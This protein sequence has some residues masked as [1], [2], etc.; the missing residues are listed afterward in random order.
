MKSIS[1]SDGQL[2]SIL[3]RRDLQSAAQLTAGS[4]LG[5]T[6]TALRL[7]RLVELGFIVV[8]D[9]A[10]DVVV[11]RL[12]PR[13]ATPDELD[14]SQR[15]LL[16]ESELIL[17]ELVSTILE[18]EGYAVIAA[19]APA[20]AVAI[21]ARSSFDLVITDGFSRTA[22][23]ALVRVAELRKAAGATPVVLF[24]AHK[25]DVDAVLA[26]GFRDLIEKPFSLDRVRKQDASAAPAGQ[27][28]S[29]RA[30]RGGCG[31]E[32]RGEPGRDAARGDGLTWRG[33][34]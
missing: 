34:R 21:L 32:I 18:D 6:E 33:S 2:L 27:G 12:R 31:G 8:A 28:R 7:Q 19:H 1:G 4:G 22:G 3:A 10:A 29:R 11:Y 26:A 15:I 20:E 30:C 24:T 9:P 5:P 14:P 23:A 17:G 25:L 16:I 13:S